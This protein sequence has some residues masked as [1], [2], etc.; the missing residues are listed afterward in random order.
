MGPK[1]PLNM[2]G[3][4]EGGIMPNAGGMPIMGP[5]PMWPMFMGPGGLRLPLAGPDGGRRGGSGAGRLCGLAE[6]HME[7]Q[8]K[9]EGVV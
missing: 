5:C 3:P 9:T 6:T 8:Q 2:G 4:G 1:F 7:N